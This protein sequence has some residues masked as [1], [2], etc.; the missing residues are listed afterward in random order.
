MK[1]CQYIKCDPIYV[2]Y[3]H[4]A[5]YTGIFIMWG[6][7]AEKSEIK[8]GVMGALSVILYC[9]TNHPTTSDF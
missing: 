6:E 8:R 1:I 2:F 7:R 4:V 5:I 9:I 3:L